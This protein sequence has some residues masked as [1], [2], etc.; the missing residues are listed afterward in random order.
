MYG[1]IALGITLTFGIT[2]IVNFA[3]GEFMMVG[4]Y[5]TYALAEHGACPTRRRSCPPA[6]SP[7]PPATSPTRPSFR[8]TPQQSRQRPPRLHR[9]HLPLRE[10]FDARLDGHAARDASRAAGSLR[11]GDLGLPKMKLVVFG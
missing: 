3:L 10:R 8:F 4:A 5:A 6:S 11:V 7:P 2:G 1:I 9:P